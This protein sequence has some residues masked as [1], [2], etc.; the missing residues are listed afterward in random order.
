MLYGYHMELVFD[1][2]R[3]NHN[4]NVGGYDHLHI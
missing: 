2:I 1:S 4:E 3:L